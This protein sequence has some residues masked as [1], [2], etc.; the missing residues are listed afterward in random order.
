MFVL[1]DCNS[2]VDIVTNRSDTRYRHDEFCTIDDTCGS[3]KAAGV[4]VH[5]GWI[6]AHVGIPN[7][8]DADKHAK[9]MAARVAKGLVEVDNK[10]AIP[11]AI[12]IAKRIS[13]AIW[14]TRWSRA[15][16]VS[17]RCH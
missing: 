6:P 17:W 16:H 8:E 7:N 3:L 1:T 11:A 14:Q 13:T 2:V 5:I 4:N 15:L 12:K 10:I 9:A